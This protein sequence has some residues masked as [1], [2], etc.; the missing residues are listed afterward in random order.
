MSYVD[1]KKI[2][3]TTESIFVSDA[4]PL[5]IKM[6]APNIAAFNTLP[7]DSKWNGMLVYL[8][9]AGTWN[10]YD[11][12]NNTLVLFQSCIMPNGIRLI[13]KYPGNVNTSILETNDIV[14]GFIEN[15]FMKARYN[16]GNKDA[17]ASYTIV[18]EHVII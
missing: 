12:P 13:W 5:D 4:L 8:E 11:K 14:E 10:K 16:T 7:A 15:R 18:E 17:V 6:F 3:Q 2:A 9:D 1:G